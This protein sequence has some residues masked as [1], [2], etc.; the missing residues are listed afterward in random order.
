MSLLPNH[1]AKTPKYDVYT[2][3]GEKEAVPS[4]GESGSDGQAS[5]RGSLE[6]L[7]W[8]AP[9][10]KQDQ[11]PK[12]STPIYPE[13]PPLIDIPK[14][15]MLDDSRNTSG[16]DEGKKFKEQASVLSS[17]RSKGSGNV[18]QDRNEASDSGGFRKPRT[19]FSSLISTKS[20]SS[21]DLRTS[22]GTGS[23]KGGTSGSKR[24]PM[25]GSSRVSSGSGRTITPSSGHSRT[26]GSGC[27]RT[28]GE[29]RPSSIVAV[30]EGRGQARGEVGVASVDLRCPQLS[31]AQFSDTHTYTR[32]IT[33]LAIFNPLEVIV[34]STA[35]PTDFSGRVGGRGLVQV[36]QESL[37]ETSVTAV[38]RR[39]FNDTRGL[40]I[41][42]HLASPECAYVERHISSKYYC[43]AAVAALMKY[44]E[45]IQH[46]TYA[47]HS[48]HI[49]LSSSENTMFI[50]YSSCR[51]LELVRSLRGGWEN[52]LFGALKH[53]RTLGGARLLRASLLQPHADVATITSR[54]NALQYLVENPDLF[55][56]LQS[57]LGR[58]PDIDWLLSMC[59]QLPKEETEQR[60]ELRL[61]YVI[62]LKNTLELLDPLR[63]ALEEVSDPLLSSVKEAVKSQSL[64]DLLD[65]LREVLHED[66]R[67]VKG[68]ASM[69]TQRCYAIKSDVNGLLDV[70]RKIYSEIIDDITSHVEELA[71]ELKLALRVGHNAARGFH[72][73]ISQK[74]KK[75]GA[76]HLPPV[77]IQVQRGKG[78]VTCTTEQLYQLDHRSRDTLREILIMSNVIVLEMLVEARGRIGALHA[79]GEAVSTLDLVVALTHAASI[80]SWVRPEFSPTLAIEKGR[81]PILD[82]LSSAEPVPNNTFL[83]SESCVI[84]LTGPNMSGK[85]T[86]L[87]QIA[88]IQILAQLGSFVPADF[89]SIKLIRQLFTHLGS[90]DSPENNASTF[91]VQMSD[92]A[93]MLGEAN[94]DSLVLLDELGSG[95]SIEEGG[96]LAWAV[97]EMLI[98]AKVPTVLATHTL[99]LTKLADLYPSVTN[100]HL[101]HEESCGGRLKLT[102]VVRPGVTRATHYG[103][104]LARVT[105]IPRGVVNRAEEL[106]AAMEPATQITSESDNQSAEHRAVYHLAHQLLKL[107]EATASA[108]SPFLGSKDGETRSPVAVN[109]ASLNSASVTHSSSDNPNRD[110]NESFKSGS[111]I[112]IRSKLQVLLQQFLEQIDHKKSCFG[113][114]GHQ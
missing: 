102:H 41:V 13:G 29:P 84:V 99:F 63:M 51:K 82:V 109:E 22:T 11:I 80:G 106:A 35:V 36:I 4:C 44:V 81:H 88:L 19:P 3:D 73:S 18:L 110:D 112:E 87:R 64:K 5:S 108:S 28:P 38:Q 83:S 34:A 70:A 61:N 58:F 48:L 31:L 67:L 54:H 101:E 49:T 85:S 40:A 52:S 46:V 55:F 15:L 113:E 37:S 92:V 56:T 98:V 89:A 103:I 9:V 39:Y 42:K 6:K 30:V 33:K 45:H 76:L 97:M 60:C 16:S 43:L 20:T 10:P 8:R 7:Q 53:T 25:M 75:A 17:L 21:D 24:T 12:H 32:T 94:P 74:K 47:P 69:R 23:S 68:T 105:A 66:A 27:Q 14:G 50:D 107:S 72:I 59:V 26:P 111:S 93:H 71:K 91:Q 57:I 65:M 62:A 90:E 79:L 1:K 78:G 114:V 77:L 104:A 96:S 86:Y 95:T 100:Y 2:E